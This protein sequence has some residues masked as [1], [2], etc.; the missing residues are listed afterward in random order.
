MPV[1]RSCERD[2]HDGASCCGYCGATLTGPG[3]GA[4]AAEA[5]PQGADGGYWT[6][7]Q[8][9]SENGD[10]AL[11]CLVC[12][13]LRAEPATIARVPPPSPPAGAAR[14]PCTTCGQANDA[15]VQFCTYCGVAG[16]PVLVE[17]EPAPQVSQ[18]AD[19][20]VGPLAPHP[21]A[22]VRPPAPTQQVTPVAP[23][24]P[25]HRGPRRAGMTLGVWLV[26]LGGFLVFAMSLGSWRGLWPSSTAAQSWGNWVY[27]G[28]LF[29][30]T[31]SKCLCLVAVV[32]AL[33][34][35]L[36]GTRVSGRALRNFGL[37]ALAFIVALPVYRWAVWSIPGAVN[38]TELLALIGAQLMIFGGMLMGPAPPSTSRPSVRP[39]SVR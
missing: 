30:W 17:P 24:A 32:Q 13:A 25:M 4:V 39:T 15:A 38:A 37:V 26:M 21:T 36:A 10:A 31:T 2:V 1:C 22:S 7:S 33:R 19:A 27:V 9:S 20:G 35:G 14:W 5:P 18:P 16:G 28:L 12:G 6:C 29:G 11:F 8:C 23:V 3:P 34:R